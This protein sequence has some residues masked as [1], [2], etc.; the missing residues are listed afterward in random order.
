MFWDIFHLDDNSCFISKDQQLY[1]PEYM[2][3][4]NDIGQLCNY[5]F[6]NDENT[7][8]FSGYQNIEHQI[9]SEL[10]DWGMDFIRGLVVNNVL[11]NYYQNISTFR[12]NYFNSKHSKRYL[13]KYDEF[14]STNYWIDLFS[15]EYKVIKKRSI[16]IDAP[17]L[18]K[19][20]FHRTINL[21]TLLKENNNL[22]IK[23]LNNLSGF[24]SKSINNYYNNRIIKIN[25]KTQSIIIF[26]TI[27]TVF[28]G[29]IQI[30]EID[31]VKEIYK[32]IYEYIQIV[33]KT[34][35]QFISP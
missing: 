10:H 2:N 18:M 8:V 4:A 3:L 11:D 35:K 34:I 14:Q 13:R 32:K 24:I 20:Q 12:V 7:E 17:I 28:I 22:K 29:L 31:T 6:L 27:T 23:A 15:R 21:S 19:N 16:I 5:F 33:L 9:R 1:F 30:S 26:L 25:L